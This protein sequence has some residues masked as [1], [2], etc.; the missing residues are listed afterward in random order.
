MGVE[1][2]TEIS[3]CDLAKA[4]SNLDT[5]CWISIFGILLIMMGATL[6]Q[7]RCSTTPVWKIRLPENRLLRLINKRVSFEFVGEQLKGS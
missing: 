3:R 1:E 7:K 2:V 6:A 4:S 5:L